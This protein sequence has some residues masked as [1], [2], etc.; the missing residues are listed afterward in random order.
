MIYSETVLEERF[1]LSD[2][3]VNGTSVTAIENLLEAMTD[4]VN[5]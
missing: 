2:C 4:G 1:I 3:P 5:W